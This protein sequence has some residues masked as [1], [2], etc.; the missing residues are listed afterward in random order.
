MKNFIQLLAFSAM[1]TFVSCGEDYSEKEEGMEM[2]KLYISKSKP[3]PGE[4][5]NIRYSGEFNQKTEATVNY[6][7]KTKHYPVDLEFRDSAGTHYASLNIPD[8]IQAIAFNFKNNDI[9]E[10]N[11]RKGYVMP[12]YDENGEQV[13]GALA[14]RGYYY[15]NQADRYNVKVEPDSVLVLMEKELEK[16]P[17]LEK[18]YEA[19]YAEVLLKSDRKKGLEYIDKRIADY[20]GRDSLETKGINSLYRLYE[21]KGAD[22]ESDS[23]KAIALEKYP[24]S[25]VA[26]MDLVMKAVRSKDL[27]EKVNS[28]KKFEELG[29][30]NENFRNVML[31]YIAMA[32]AKEQNWE[33]FQK[34]VNKIDTE[35]TKAGLYNSV[36]WELAEKG[37][38]L[39]KAAELSKESLEILRKS[40]GDY[41]NKPD[42]YSRKQYDK[43]LAF[44]ESMYGDTYAFTLYKQGKIEEAIAIQEK[45]LTDESSSDMTTRYVEY[46]IEAGDY[47]K[48]LDKAEQFIIENRAESEMK[49]YLKKAY[50]EGDNDDDFDAYYASLEEKAMEK[51]RENLLKEMLDEEAPSFQLTDLQGNEVALSSMKGK[52]VILDFWATW[53]G[54]CKKSFPG[55]QKAVEKYA[56]NENVE[57]L[58]V[59][60]WEPGEDRDEKVSD[61]IEKNDYDFHV[62]MDEVV[63]DG[64]RDFTVVSDYGINGIPTKIIIGPKGNINFRKVGYS[65]NNEKML[66]E[67]GLM[68]ELTQKDSQ[69]EA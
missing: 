32:Y 43:S 25:N 56:S 42:Y 54:P 35:T 38:E 50:S 36:A 2:G 3:Q 63:A 40:E 29:I 24:K 21:I 11:N 59:N 67:I 65:G 57:F 9:F 5:I 34:Y 28:F 64:S 68:I 60:T 13:K 18:D 27:E 20:F 31:R 55:M 33:E 61:F 8:T 1:V 6:L 16:N 66:K 22:K 37:E 4:T 23:L 41:E 69:P 62:I 49:E 15:T 52:T 12:L 26:Q 44:S 53:C 39:E 10:S 17:E 7:V 46:L 45:A 30:D 48:T 51:A 58:F 47:K 14:S 19:S